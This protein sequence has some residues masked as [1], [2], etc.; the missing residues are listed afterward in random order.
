M[1]NRMKIY[2]VCATLLLTLAACTSAGT[3]RNGTPTAVYAGSS[4]AGDVASCVSAAWATKHYQISTEPLV[5]GTSLQ[6]RATDN[7]PILALVDIVPVG[8]KTVATY[9]SRMPDDDSWFFKEVKGCM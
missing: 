2:L 4:S 1:K 8:E 9:Y 5:S 3:L 6:L 7:G